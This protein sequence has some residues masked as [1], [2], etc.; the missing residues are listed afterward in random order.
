MEYGSKTSGVSRVIFYEIPVEIKISR[1]SPEAIFLRSVLVRTRGAVSIKSSADIIKWN[2]CQYDAI[3]FGE[4]SGMDKDI[5]QE[6]HRC[7]HAIGLTGMNGVVD[8]KYCF[9]LRF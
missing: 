9:S 7:V 2:D 3:H 5:T 6:H 1:I 4:F 8:Q